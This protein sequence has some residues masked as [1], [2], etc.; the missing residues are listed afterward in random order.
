M[1]ALGVAH[2][3]TDR[4]IAA[5]LPLLRA[6]RRLYCLDGANCFNPY[7]L[8]AAA[9]Q[10]GLDPEGVLERVFVS[11]AYTCHQL[12]E[13]AETMLPPLVTE[14]A[15]PLADESEPPLVGL[16]GIDR[17]FLDEDLP[18]HERRHLY[19]RML[20][21][22]GLMHRRGL[23]IFITFV[24]DPAGPWARALGRAA[25]LLPEL[26]GDI[27][28]AIVDFRERLI[29]GTHTADLQHLPGARDGAVGAVS[30]GAAT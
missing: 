25:P 11:R 2:S 22:A 27:R 21:R 1:M 3:Q 5:F 13:A 18:L 23:P 12:A 16:L 19:G 28:G 20:E 14:A 15:G 7:R 8:A 4:V 24:S 30:A 9:R 17:L 29:H 26:H 6:G 10:R